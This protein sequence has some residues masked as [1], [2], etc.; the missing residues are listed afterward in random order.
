MITNNSQIRKINTHIRQYSLTPM[1]GMK[2]RS[3]AEDGARTDSG[4][5]APYPHSLKVDE[6][7]TNTEIQSPTSTTN[8][9]STMS[10]PT[11]TGI[12]V[13]LAVVTPLSSTTTPQ[14]FVSDDKPINV[15]ATVSIAAARDGPTGVAATYAVV[16]AVTNAVAD[17][18]ATAAVV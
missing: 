1:P 16:H 17:G 5:A 8:D 10:S 3:M 4:L 9:G 7:S 14:T 15:N 6:H 12:A 18:V 13:E 11:Q 2:R